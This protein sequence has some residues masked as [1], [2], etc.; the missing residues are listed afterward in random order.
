ML[1]VG[2]SANGDNPIVRSD[3]LAAGMDYVLAKPLDMAAFAACLIASG[4]RLDRPVGGGQL[5]GGGETNCQRAGA[6]LSAEIRPFPLLLRLLVD[7]RY[8]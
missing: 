3:C 8:S 2:I 1:I 6:R 7:L 5:D 4:D